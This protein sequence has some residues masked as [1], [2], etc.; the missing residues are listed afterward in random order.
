MVE[1]SS[2][3]AITLEIGNVKSTLR[4]LDYRGRAPG[5]SKVK[6]LIKP[7][8]LGLFEKAS[9]L[10]SW[11]NPPPGKRAL[12]KRMPHLAPPMLGRHCPSGGA[13]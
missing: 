6:D 4:A 2:R 1:A 13:E 7:V 12:E 5:D 8:E 11:G 9:E 3:K 10:E